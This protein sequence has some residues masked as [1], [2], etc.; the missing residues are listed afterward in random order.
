[1]FKVP[2]WKQKYQAVMRENELLR[3][4]MDELQIERNTLKTFYDRAVEEG[5]KLK[6]ANDKL[7]DEINN[8]KTQQDEIVHTGIRLWLEKQEKPGK[9]SGKKPKMNMQI[10]NSL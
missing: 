8:L 3:K 9:S 2:H 7:L 4:R 10:D 6:A 5:N 1:M